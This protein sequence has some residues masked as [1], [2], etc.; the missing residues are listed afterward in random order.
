MLIP[1]QSWWHLVAHDNLLLSCS[2][3]TDF[4]A[5]LP[6]PTHPYWDSENWINVPLVLGMIK[7][8]IMT[9]NRNIAQNSSTRRKR[10]KICE[11]SLRDVTISKI[12]ESYPAL[13]K[14]LFRKG[15]S[16]HFKVQ[17][18]P[19]GNLLLP[20]TYLIWFKFSLV[21]QLPMP[22]VSKFVRSF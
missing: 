16:F 8:V 19:L 7:V 10:S 13:S 3:S 17:S 6:I 15:W 5:L 12:F 2:F 22:E 21:L 1:K 4:W 9:P 14:S 20:Q 18:W 11:I